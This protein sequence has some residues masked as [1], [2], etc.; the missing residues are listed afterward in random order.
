M[1]P[2]SLFIPKALVTKI[3]KVTAMMKDGKA[4]MGEINST[5]IKNGKKF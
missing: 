2:N 5:L 3:D 4:Q 1:T